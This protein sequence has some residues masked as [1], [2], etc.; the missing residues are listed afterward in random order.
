LLCDTD[1]SLASAF[2]VL[3]PEA[4]GFRE[5]ARRSLFLIDEE[6]TIS[7]RWV[8]EDNWNEDGSNFGTNPV[9]AA[10]REL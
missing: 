2:G 3:L 4:D 7:Y 5:V 8:A 1:R 6:G 10:I 9:E